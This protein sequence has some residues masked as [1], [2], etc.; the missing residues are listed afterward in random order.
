M[1]IVIFFE[2]LPVNGLPLASRKGFGTPW[3]TNSKA[4]KTPNRHVSRLE[5]SAKE[6]VML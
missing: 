1:V 6:L 5:N 4:A 3:L 2:I